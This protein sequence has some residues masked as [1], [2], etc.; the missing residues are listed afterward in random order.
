MRFYRRK[1]FTF[2]YISGDFK[3]GLGL[4]VYNYYAI[5]KPRSGARD[6]PRSGARAGLNRDEVHLLEGRVYEGC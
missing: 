3:A 6:K 2:T 4:R 1:L 5:F